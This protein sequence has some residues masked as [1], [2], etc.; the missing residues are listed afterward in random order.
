VRLKAYCVT[1]IFEQKYYQW[2][3]AALNSRLV[4][5]YAIRAEFEDDEVQEWINQAREFLNEVRD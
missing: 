4:G 5:D 2:L 1:G 3:I